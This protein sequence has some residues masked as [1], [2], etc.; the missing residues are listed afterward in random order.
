MD[1]MAGSIPQQPSSGWHRSC[2]LNISV[3]SNDLKI[4]VASLVDYNLSQL[5]SADFRDSITSGDELLKNYITNSD[6]LQEPMELADVADIDD[7][8]VDVEDDMEEIQRL[9][10]ELHRLLTLEQTY[11]EAVAVKSQTTYLLTANDVAQPSERK[12]IDA[13]SC[14]LGR[15]APLIESLKSEELTAVYQ[16]LTDRAEVINK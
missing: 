15:V 1:S 6:I 16:E 4:R 5:C 14:Y 7:Q 9:R 3:S 11:T 13:L 12:N 2:N 10:Q 8:T